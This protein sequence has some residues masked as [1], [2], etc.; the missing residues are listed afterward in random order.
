MSNDKGLG[1]AG[2]WND[3][4]AFGGPG[5][6]FA[7]WPTS[8]PGAVRG[9][10]DRMNKK[11]PGRTLAQRTATAPTVAHAA[12][13]EGAAPERVT[14]KAGEK[15]LLGEA[16][17]Q[18]RQAADEVQ[19]RIVT[20]GVWLLR[21][22]FA[23]DARAALGDGGPR[24]AIEPGVPADN[25]VWAELLRRAGGPT[26][27]L[28]PRMLS[29]ALRA[30]AWDKLIPDESWRSLDVGRKELLLPLA[31]PALLRE[32]AQHVVAMRL[33]QRATRGYVQATLQAHRGERPESRVTAKRLASS[34]RSTRERLM[35]G[36]TRRRVRQFKKLGGEERKVLAAEVDALIAALREMKRDLSVGK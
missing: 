28:N 26:L 11:P 24:R 32:G 1:T 20:L 21:H 6:V 19:D 25:R 27:R 23:G 30:A 18:C 5:R 3:L 4:A 15:T 2:W 34:L 33:T 8:R 16:L 7:G 31:E 10:V 13:R 29:V 22:V 9:I 12:A 35:D 17:E 36:A 14:L